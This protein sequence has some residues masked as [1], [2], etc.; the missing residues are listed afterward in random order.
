MQAFFLSNMV[1]AFGHA[2]VLRRPAGVSLAKA[3]AET[4]R[5]ILAYLGW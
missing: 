1:D 4:L 5:A 2:I 3:K